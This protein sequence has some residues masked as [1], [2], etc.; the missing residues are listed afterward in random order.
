MVQQKVVYLEN[1]QKKMQIPFFGA[2]PYYVTVASQM[3]RLRIIAV[4]LIYFLVRIR[5]VVA[6]ASVPFKERRFKQEGLTLSFQWFLVVSFCKKQF[7]ITRVVMRVPQ[8][9]SLRLYACNIETD[10]GFIS[11]DGAHVD[12]N[13]YSRGV[14][15]SYDGAMTRA[16]GELLERIPFYY[17][18][19]SNLLKYS[20]GELGASNKKYVG[21][22]IDSNVIMRALGHE[23]MIDNHTYLNWVKGQDLDGWDCLLPAAAI[24]GNYDFTKGQLSLLECE[25]STHG[26]GSHV[27]PEEALNHGLCEWVERDGFFHHWIFGLPG[28][29]LN[30]Q[31]LSLENEAFNRV[32]RVLTENGFEARVAEVTSKEV[33][34]PTFTASVYSSDKTKQCLGAGC[35]ADWRKAAYSAIIEAAGGIL[36]LDEFYQPCEK[37]R[38]MPVERYDTKQRLSYFSS[39]KGIDELNFIFEG[40]AR[41]SSYFDTKFDEANKACADPV[42][43]FEYVRTK[44]KNNH[45]LKTGYVLLQKGPFE[46]IKAYSCKVYCDGLITPY[47]YLGYRTPARIEERAEKYGLKIVN[48]DV[49]PFI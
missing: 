7:G 20:L 31:S 34:I 25:I 33:T 16:F 32:L 10:N 1:P 17:Y 18:K 41:D 49:H 8:V 4:F 19:E 14:D 23:E 22:L 48:K 47:Q 11:S 26:T 21:T 29:P 9:G 40:N 13:S 44:F 43:S 30:I 39:S 45:S 24:F 46:R 35:D 12:I 15:M 3:G 42:S 38:S 2:S 36:W 6:D 5:Y 27:S 37:Y 28:T